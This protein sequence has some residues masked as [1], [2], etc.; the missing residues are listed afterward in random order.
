MTKC[1]TWIPIGPNSLA[2]LWASPRNAN[3][4][5]AKAEDNGKPLTLAVAPVSRIAP[6]PFGVIRRAACRTTRKPPKAETAIAWRTWSGS[7]ST[8]R[9]RTRP[10]AL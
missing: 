1:A 10:D 3:F 4:P 6:R 5:M 2:A 8:M 7:S 9:P